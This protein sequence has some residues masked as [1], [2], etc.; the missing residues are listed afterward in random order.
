M[1]PTIINSQKVFL[2]CPVWSCGHWAG[3]VYPAKTPNSKWLHWYS[4]TFNTVEGNSTFYA[5]PSSATIQRWV[6]QTPDTFR[7]ALKFP[8]VISHDLALH[9]AESQTRDFLHRIE[10]LQA[11]GRLGPTFLQLGPRF[12]PHRFP[13]LVRYLEKL[14]RDFKWAVELRHVDWFDL[15]NNE[16]KVNELLNRLEI[17]KVL[18]DSRPLFQSPPDDEIEKVSQGRKPRTPVRQTITGKFPMLRLVGRNNVELVDQFLDQWAPIIAGWVQQDLTPFVFA[19]APDDKYAVRFA[20]RLA[21]RLQAE[22]PELDCSI[23]YPESERQLSLLDENDD[24][25]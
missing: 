25:K 5:L 4:R 14:P 8:K 11:A 10:P 19:H 20:R 13:L 12:G 24:S 9:N 15:G 22:L 7:F 1:K 21:Q 2:G 3:E 16:R 18:F 17:D 6:E 23:P